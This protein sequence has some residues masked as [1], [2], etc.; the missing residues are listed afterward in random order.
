MKVCQENFIKIK[1]DFECRFVTHPKQ[2]CCKNN[3]WGWL[4]YTKN[5]LKMFHPQTKLQHQIC[6]MPKVFYK[7]EKGKMVTVILCMPSG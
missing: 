7:F 3:G 5:K 4:S 2:M 6:W 1:S